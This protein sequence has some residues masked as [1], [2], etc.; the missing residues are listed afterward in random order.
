MLVM[1]DNEC[2]RE[3]AFA[4]VL[5]GMTENAPSMLGKEVAD[6]DARKVVTVEGGRNVL[7]PTIGKCTLSN[8]SDE[9]GAA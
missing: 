9:A 3:M 1:C 4:S 5:S 7:T 8:S 2:C 6:D